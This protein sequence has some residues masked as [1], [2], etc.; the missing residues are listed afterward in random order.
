MKVWRRRGLAHSRKLR[1]LMDCGE[2]RDD[3]PRLERYR[4]GVRSVAPALLASVA[5]WRKEDAA[6]YTLSCAQSGCFAGTSGRFH[7]RRLA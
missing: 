3:T 2:R 1:V 4:V 7:E 6:T 5:M